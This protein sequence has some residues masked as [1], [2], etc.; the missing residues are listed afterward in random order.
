MASLP[1]AFTSRVYSL[2]PRNISFEKRE[3]PMKVLSTV[4]RGLALALGWAFAFAGAAV[5]W[6][7]RV[8]LQW[9]PAAWHVH[10][11]FWL[12]LLCSFVVG[13]P[14]GCVG[15]GLIQPGKSMAD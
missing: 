3:S 11:S 4:T 7:G 9:F 1:F 2:L 13:L 12:G 14:L 15:M 5:F 8:V 10:D 6:Q